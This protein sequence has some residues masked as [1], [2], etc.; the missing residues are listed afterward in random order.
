MQTARP[1][2]T[3]IPGPTNYRNQECVLYGV[4]NEE[5][6]NLL[7]QRLTGLCDPGTK[8]FSEHEMV[9]T[10]KVASDNQV[11]VRMRR[12]LKSD[13]FFWHARY[14][15]TP[16]PAPN[17]P[18]I[19]RKTIDSSIFSPGMMEFIKA[20]G[21][22]IDYELMM[23]GILFTKGNIRVTVSHITYT[24]KTGR[25]ESEYRKPLSNSHFVEA[26][27]VIPENQEYMSS[28]KALREFADHLAPLCELQ[29]FD[30]M[31]A[32]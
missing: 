4:V 17:C 10:L 7:I 18:A 8:A 21:L 16:E 13:H 29:K 25:Y 31:K 3:G 11:Q 28:A 32:A 27:V 5:S 1:L 30:Y 23:D 24:E 14:I 19:V 9:F 2:H 22:R 26:S 20:L 6:K 12:R 15:S